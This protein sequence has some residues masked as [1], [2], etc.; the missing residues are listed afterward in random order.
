MPDDSLNEYHSLDTG[1]AGTLPDAWLT[2]YEGRQM[3]CEQGVPS[4]LTAHT[5][6]PA[7]E[8][9]TSPSS[10]DRLLPPASS[11]GRTSTPVS[12]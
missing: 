2:G 4:R 6:R 7:A 3:V 10:S 11:P 9:D 5:R 8:T 12:R 1:T